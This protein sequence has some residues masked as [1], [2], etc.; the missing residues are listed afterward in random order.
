MPSL[1]FGELESAMVETTAYTL[2][3]HGVGGLVLTAVAER[4]ADRTRVRVELGRVA[5]VLAQLDHQPKQES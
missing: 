1:Q 4:S 2:F 3:L 5:K